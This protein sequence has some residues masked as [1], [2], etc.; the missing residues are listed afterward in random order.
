MESQKE[1]QEYQIEEKIHTNKTGKEVMIQRTFDDKSYKLT[2]KIDKKGHRLW[3]IETPMTKEELIEFQEHFNHMT[4]PENPPGR[5]GF[6]NRASHKM[7]CACSCN[8]L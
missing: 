4:D 1:P 3:K 7:G 8:I 6:G 5:K 2:K